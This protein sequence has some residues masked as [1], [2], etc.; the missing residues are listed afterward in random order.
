M[1]AG[2]DQGATDSL[3]ETCKLNRVDPKA[4]LSAT[5]TRPVAGDPASALDQLMPRTSAPDVA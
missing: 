4:W 1:F 3:I 2:S 5:P